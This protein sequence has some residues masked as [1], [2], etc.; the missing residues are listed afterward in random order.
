MEKSLTIH[1]V[2]PTFVQLDNH[3]QI[4]ISRLEFKN[5]E[6]KKDLCAG[7][8]QAKQKLRTYF[9]SMIDGKTDVYGIAM[10]LD[11][12]RKLDGFEML[13]STLL[14]RRQVRDCCFDYCNIILILP[15]PRVPEQP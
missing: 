15:G 1:Y 11:P 9:N 5:T 7:L 8:K 10:F 3:L 14:D 2:I 12:Q 6:W 4:Y 13:Q